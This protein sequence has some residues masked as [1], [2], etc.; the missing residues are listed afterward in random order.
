MLFRPVI[1]L[2]PIHGKYPIGG[3]PLPITWPKVVKKI[4]LT[5]PRKYQDNI[6]V[7]Q[8]NEDPIN[9]NENS[10]TFCFTRPLQDSFRI[11]SHF[12]LN[13]SV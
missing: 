6:W 4:V 13:W 1:A 7:K 12:D 3:E 9:Y 11:Y 8:Y 2:N 10:Q 5:M